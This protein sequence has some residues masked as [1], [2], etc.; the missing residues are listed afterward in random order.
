MKAEW[1]DIGERG[2]EANGAGL[3]LAGQIGLGPLFVEVRKGGALGADEVESGG[4]ADFLEGFSEKLL[5]P[6]GGGFG[7]KSEELPLF[8]TAGADFREGGHGIAPN[9]FRWV[10]K[11]REEPLA[12]RLFEGGLVGL[13]EAGADGADEGDTL[14]FFL[15]R[16]GKVSGNLFLP[17]AEPRHEAEFPIEILGRAGLFFGH[18]EASVWS[19]GNS[20]LDGEQEHGKV[21]RRIKV[22]SRTA[23]V[24]GSMRCSSHDKEQ[25]DS[26]GSAKSW[27]SGLADSKSEYARQGEDRVHHDG[28][29]AVARAGV[30]FP[31][32]VSVGSLGDDGVSAGEADIGDGWEGDDWRGGEGGVGQE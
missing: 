20:S 25:K 9:F 12:D 1:G 6:I 14:D 7:K 3:L 32:G 26:G 21:G 18:R 4:A 15:G 19:G 13:R 31:S 16:G 23:N 17:Q 11:K 22:L 28:V 5:F 27:R 30:E 29:R 10:L 8:G 2:G 24:L